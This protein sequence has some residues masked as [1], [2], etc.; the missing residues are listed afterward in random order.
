MSEADSRSIPEIISA[1]TGDLANL[2]RKESE[3][4]RTEVSE[5]ISDAAKAG[6]SMS[7]G[8]ALLLGGFLCLIA[9]LVLGL[10]HIMD[11]AW[12]ALLVG[13]VAGLVGYTLVR[14]AAKK[15]QPAALTP[16]RATRQ[17]HKDA[18]LVK[19]QVR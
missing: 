2:V 17:I 15:V 7:I 16:D 18:Q 19:E 6:V 14:G 5:K 12:A 4:V 10:S 1:V 9:A 8:A 11:P 3:L 13:V